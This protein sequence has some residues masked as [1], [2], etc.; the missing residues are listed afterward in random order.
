M[1]TNVVTVSPEQTVQEA[2]NLMK[3]NDIGSLPV[4]ENGQLVG[5]LTDR[6]IALRSTAEGDATSESV[7]N[8]MSTNI[9]TASPSTDAEDA[10]E[11]MAQHQIRRLPVVENGQLVGMIALGDLALDNTIQD[12][13][14][15]ALSDISEHT[16]ANR[17]M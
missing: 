16:Q 14:G 11:M 6:D 15:E 1:T 7:R 4:V 13:A 9:A 5:I 2:A 8:C 3:Q 10:A 12:E 17:R